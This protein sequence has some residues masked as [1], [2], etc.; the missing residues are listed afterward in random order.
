M[1]QNYLTLTQVA[2]LLR[3]SNPT[4][5]K[6]IKENRFVGCHRVGREWFFEAGFGVKA[7]SFKAHELELLNRLVANN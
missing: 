4:V 7:S 3:L 6:W 1:T 2:E 5:R